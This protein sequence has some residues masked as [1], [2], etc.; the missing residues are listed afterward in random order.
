MWTI[1]SL[2]LVAFV[3]SEWLVTFPL[4]RRSKWVFRALLIVVLFIA[5]VV[6]TG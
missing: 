1:G 5:W 3:V 2:L 4:R 6:P